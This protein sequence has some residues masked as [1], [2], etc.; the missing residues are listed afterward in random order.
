M[1][2]RRELARGGVR[3]YC[4]KGYRV[5]VW[6][7]K[8]TRGQCYGYGSVGLGWDSMILNPMEPIAIFFNVYLV[9]RQRETEHEW[10]R[11]RERGRHKIRSRLQALR[12]QPRDWRGARTHKPWDHDLSWSRTFNRL[13][14][15]G[16]PP[17]PFF[18]NKYFVLLPLLHTI[19]RIDIILW[20]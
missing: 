9:L 10:G 17:L 20:L 2:G 16:A 8:V 15:P 13:S 3:S 14:H 11:G 1:S 6:E 19:L 4:F 5:P 18:N 12:H 7:D